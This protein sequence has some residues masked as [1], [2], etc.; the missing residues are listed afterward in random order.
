MPVTARRSFRP[1][2]ASPCHPC[3]L[4]TLRHYYSREVDAFAARFGKRLWITGGWVRAELSGSNYL[5]DFDCIIVAGAPQIKQFAIVAARRS[6]R[7]A[8][9]R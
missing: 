7:H 9:R 6:A 4:H 8:L 1:G 3:G 2:G 5:G